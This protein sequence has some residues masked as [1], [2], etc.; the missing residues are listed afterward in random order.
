MRFQEGPYPE[1][2]QSVRFG[3]SRADGKLGRGADIYWGP[4]SVP[5]PFHML[6]RFSL[7]SVMEGG[8]LPIL[9]P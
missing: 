7:S 5:A 3:S 4:F 6:A 2:Q 8:R 9:L 1:R